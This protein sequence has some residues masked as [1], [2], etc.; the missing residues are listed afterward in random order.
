MIF[1][2]F[3][4]CK[5]FLD[6]DIVIYYDRNGDIIPDDKIDSRKLN[7][8]EVIGSSEPLKTLMVYLDV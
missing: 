1:K 7:S 6:S 4:K 5:L 3:K 2:E 8:K